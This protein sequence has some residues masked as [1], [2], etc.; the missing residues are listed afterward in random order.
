LWGCKNSRAVRAL[1]TA[2]GDPDDEVRD[3]AAQA[4]VFNPVPLATPS[5]IGL[6]ADV[7]VRKTAAQALSAIRDRQAV[8]ALITALEEIHQDYVLHEGYRATG[9]MHFGF[10]ARALG[11]IGEANAVTAL[12][13]ALKRA[14]MLRIRLPAW[15]VHFIEVD[16]VHALERLGD[17]ETAG[18]YWADCLPSEEAARGLATVGSAK[19]LR[20]LIGELATVARDSKEHPYEPDFNCGDPRLSLT[21]SLLLAVEGVLVR[22][23]AGASV[24]DL[25]AVTLLPDGFRFL[26]SYN[27]ILDWDE[28]REVTVDCRGTKHM[29]MKELARRGQIS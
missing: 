27:V 9:I 29:A 24:E 19:H 5:L 18:E 1:I 17:R 16:I 8:P 14:R 22:D 3:N 11:E 20:R 26:E 28:F 25:R 2:F 7:Y 21:R 6:L 4:F 23:A 10:F 12:Q 15:D 13:R